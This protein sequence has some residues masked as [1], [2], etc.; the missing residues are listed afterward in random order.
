MALILS[1]TVPTTDLGGGDTGQDAK[2]S[3]VG[4]CL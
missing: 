3:M 2:S 1:W 4:G